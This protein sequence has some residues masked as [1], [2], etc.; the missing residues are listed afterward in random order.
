MFCCAQG[1]TA[2]DQDALIVVHRPI[3]VR[4]VVS[5]LFLADVQGVEVYRVRTL[6]TH[7]LLLEQ[8]SVVTLGIS[9]SHEIRNLTEECVGLILSPL[10]CFGD[11]KL[12]VSIA[13]TMHLDQSLHRQGLEKRLEFMEKSLGELSFGR[14]FS[15][16]S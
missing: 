5:P 10:L 14:R 12:E 7:G 1:G 15:D 9:P 13:L 3:F 2:V 16:Q 8:R 6:M 11:W 4:I